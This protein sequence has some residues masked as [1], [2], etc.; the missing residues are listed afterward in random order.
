MK[1]MSKVVTHFVNLFHL[2]IPGPQFKHC[3][4]T[5]RVYK[6]QQHLNVKGKHNKLGQ[7]KT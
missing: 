2:G 1:S 3:W 5:I 6:L 7:K 4:P